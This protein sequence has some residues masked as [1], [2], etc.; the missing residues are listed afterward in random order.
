[1][2]ESGGTLSV[3]LKEMDLP[4]ERR[5]LSAAIPA[6]RYVRI[7]IA[8][9]GSGISPEV[10]E[11][12][13]DPYFTTKKMGEGTGLG[14]SVSLGIVENHGGAIDVESVPGEGTRFSLFLP[15]T[16]PA[17]PTT[18][19]EVGG[20]QPLPMG[21][22]ERILLVDDDPFLLDAI[23]KN[24][25]TLGYSVQAHQSSRKALAALEGDASAF[26]L[27]ITDQTMPEITGTQLAERVRQLRS[28]LPILLCTGYSETVT[29]KSASRFGISTFLLKPVNR[30]NLARAVHQALS[31]PDR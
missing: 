4:E 12:I 20:R 26:D 2:R 27:L 25:A 24:L 5:F 11:R 21:D 23:C 1:M 16:E 7:D 13:F 28:D 17:E 29:E 10:K 31:G 9:T 18:V 15:L 6:G 30:E 14:L 22:G 3:S 19:P 8:D